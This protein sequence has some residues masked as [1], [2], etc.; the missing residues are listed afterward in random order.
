MLD[1]AIG[2]RV[3]VAGGMGIIAAASTL[4][5]GNKLEGKDFAV[6]AYGGSSE[7]KVGFAG[8]LWNTLAFHTSYA[9]GRDT[10]LFA[11]GSLVLSGFVPADN[12][13]PDRRPS[14]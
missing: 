1:G 2:D 6:P 10:H 11:E 13:A 12:V 5:L 14:S 3:H 9:L 8:G 7:D 4:A